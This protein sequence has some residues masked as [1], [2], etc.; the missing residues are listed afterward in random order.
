MKHAL[1]LTAAL[2]LPFSATAQS[3]ESGEIDEGFSLIEEGAKLLFRG[4]LSEMEPAIEEF[5]TLGEEV[6]PTLQMLATEMGPALIEL[7]ETLDDLR[8]YEPPEILPN[9][10]VIIRRSPSAPVF[11]GPAA[12]TIDL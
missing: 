3:E 1:I 10:D 9:G 5:S 2:L 12:P 11:E 4:I 8:H 6:A 7:F